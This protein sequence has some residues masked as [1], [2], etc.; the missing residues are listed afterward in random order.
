MTYIVQRDRYRC[1]PVAI[2][3]ALRWAGETVTYE[4]DIKRLSRLCECRA[5]RG[6]THRPFLKALRKE[7]RG[8]FTV[9]LVLRPSLKDFDGPLDEGC[10]L[11]WNMKHQRGRHYA[12]IVGKR[13]ANWYDVANWMHDC[14]PVVPINRKELKQFVDQRDKLHRIWVLRKI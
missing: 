13:V 14:D 3:N 1:G 6:T 4:K 5:P 11:V 2:F 10:A 12:L 7:G 9:D 8:L